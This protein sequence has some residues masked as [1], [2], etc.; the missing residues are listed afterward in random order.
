MP[1]FDRPMACIDVVVGC[2]VW[3]NIDACGCMDLVS[4]YGSGH[5]T[6]DVY[7]EGVVCYVKMFELANP[8]PDTFSA[9]R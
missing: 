2:Y 9:D 8:R 7:R 6:T 5:F 1:I 3:D 4:G